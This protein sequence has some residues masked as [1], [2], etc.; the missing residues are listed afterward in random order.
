VEILIYIV[1][2]LCLG[3]QWAYLYSVFWPLAEYR[4]K[5]TVSSSKYDESPPVSVLI[6][7][8]NE[9]DN[10]R[11]LLPLLLNQDYE[12]S[13]D[14]HI[15]DD[16]SSDKTDEWIN[17]TF[18]ELRYKIKYHSLSISLP[19]GKK[20][21]LSYALKLPTHSFLLMTDADCRPVSK[22]WISSMVEAM[23]VKDSIVLG[24]SPYRIQPGILNGLIQLETTYTAMMYLGRALKGHPYMGVGR[25]ILYRKSALIQNKSL[26][27]YNH[28]LSGDDDLTINELGRYHKV[29]IQF[30]H[31][32]LME[33]IPKTTWSAWIN[34]K[35]RHVSTA[36]YYQPGHQYTLLLFYSSL[37]IIWMFPIFIIWYVPWIGLVVVVFKYIFFVK[38]KR[39]ISNAFN[40]HWSFFP[41]L[42]HEGLYVFSLLW[43]S[44]A[45]FIK[46]PGKW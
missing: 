7:V 38:L 11:M 27:E 45:G 31:D 3:I 20:Q 18:H 8:K 16:H 42:L 33:S 9:I 15:I 28:L 17:A 24:Y 19:G 41:W 2:F 10:L 26:S 12:G 6:I 39:L 43:L 44:P 22:K 29:A 36:R 13:F 1:F 40:Q 35:S 34:Q 21:G 37:I 30:E 25:N 14:I 5:N 46:K 23:H 4:N 32:A